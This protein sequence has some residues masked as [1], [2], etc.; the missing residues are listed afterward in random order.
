[1][2]EPTPREYATLVRS[3]LISR[4]AYGGR[5][6]MPPAEM[7]EE[8]RRRTAQELARVLRLGAV[9]G[10]T[11]SERAAVDVSMLLSPLDLKN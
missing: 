1:M 11:D 4:V 7:L 2:A 8:I 3:L 6:R 5:V 9:G 10:G